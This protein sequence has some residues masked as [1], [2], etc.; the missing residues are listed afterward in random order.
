MGQDEVGWGRG[1]WRVWEVT[2]VGVS[3]WSRVLQ[4]GGFLLTYLF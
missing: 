3:H 4:K 1:K 2:W